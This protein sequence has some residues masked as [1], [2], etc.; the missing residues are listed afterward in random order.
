VD[1]EFVEVAQGTRILIL[2]LLQAGKFDILYSLVR[3]WRESLV[4]PTNFHDLQL[5][6]HL[7]IVAVLLEL[8]F[9]VIDLS[10]LQC[11]A[12]GVILKTLIDF[13]SP[14]PEP[15]GHT[16]R[17]SSSASAP[18][19]VPKPSVFPRLSIVFRILIPAQK[20]CFRGL[21]PYKF[22]SIT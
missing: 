3:A 18:W 6:L 11:F 13:H 21:L 20:R 16:L 10:R 9:E 14:N 7:V 22:V 12:S 4:K 8:L 5:T 19:C 17:F 2:I 15:R 1:P